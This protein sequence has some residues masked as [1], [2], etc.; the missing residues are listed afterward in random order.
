MIE[1]TVLNQSKEKN[2]DIIKRQLLLKKV[3]GKILGRSNSEIVEVEEKSVKKDN[4]KEIDRNSYT[5][6]YPSE[7]NTS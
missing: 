3:D 1:D 6:S 7:S 4:P 2:I 5:D